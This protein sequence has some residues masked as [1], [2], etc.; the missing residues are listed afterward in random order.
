MKIIE[1]LIPIIV[2]IIEFLFNKIYYFS[3]LFPFIPMDK[4]IEFNVVVYT[5]ILNIL[6]N[7]LLNK[8]SYFWDKFSVN[9]EIIAYKKGQEPDITCVP[10]IILNK[11]SNVAEV[12][13]EFKIKANI[14]Q[15]KKM[16]LILNLPG[17][18]QPQANILQRPDGSYEYEISV[19]TGVNSSTTIVKTTLSENIPLIGNLSGRE[20]D[21]DIILKV[22]KPFYYMK[23]FHKIKSNSFKLKI[24]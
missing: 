6:F 17:W 14:N 8:F 9:L 1:Y 12:K 4:K 23:P 2:I 20:K 24:S 19:L 13:L 5:A 22:E 10:E 11:R 21:I 3:I 18:A 7:K 16:K 15:L